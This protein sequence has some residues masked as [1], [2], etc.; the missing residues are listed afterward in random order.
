MLRLDPMNRPGVYVHIPFC[1]AKC[2]YCTFNSY[3][4]LQHLH[5]KYIDALVTEINLWAR[6]GPTVQASS[7]YLG[8]GTPSSVSVELLGTILSTC[9]E[10]L[11]PPPGAEISIEANPGTVSAESLSALRAQGVNRLSLGA[12]SFDDSTLRLLG[13]IH[14]AT[15]VKRAYDLARRAGFRNLN[16]DLIYGLPEQTLEGWKA[17]L[18]KAVEL[19]PEHL[20]LYCLSVEEGTPLAESISQGQLPPPDS[21]LAA[22]MY[23]YAEER[24][25]EAGYEHYEI[26]N[27]ALA[28]RECQHNITYWRNLPYVGFGAGAHSF[29]AG[30][31][32]YNSSSPEEYVRRVMD[33]QEPQAGTERIDETMEMSETMILG[34]RMCEGVIFRDF[35]DRFGV[36]VIQTYGQQIAELIDLG[37]LDA[38]ASAIR[39]TA[40]GRLL[41]NEVFERFLPPGED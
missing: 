3:A 29:Y 41:G 23:V 16:L 21:D 9:R 30:A 40:R 32:C 39:L 13:R 34:L 8:G 2:S 15:D 24:L 35:Q 38:S 28:G 17:D 18:S 4:G 31:R 11:N 25:A 27:W 26:S 14:T 7:V 19:R 10:S 37:L 20:S 22:D 33:G 1:V 36:S 6:G 12:Q 5:R